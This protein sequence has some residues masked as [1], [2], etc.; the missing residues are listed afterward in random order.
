MGKGELA[1]KLFPEGSASPLP[2][3]YNPVELV[4]PD[5]PPTFLL[6]A[7]K[8]DLI[9]VEQSYDLIKRLESQGLEH[10]WAEAD[11]AHGRSENTPIEERADYERWF[12]DAIRLGL[13]WTVERLRR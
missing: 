2:P 10:G 7:T 12:E 4:S 1:L 9:P 5:F 6:V 11:M 8:D 3:T 13:D